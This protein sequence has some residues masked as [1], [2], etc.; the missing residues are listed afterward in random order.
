MTRTPSRAAIDDAVD[1][2]GT[3]TVGISTSPSSTT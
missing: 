1:E 2:R 3:T